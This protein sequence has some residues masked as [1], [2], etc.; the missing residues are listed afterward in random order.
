MKNE[1]NAK[2][3]DVE[4][5]EV[6]ATEVETEAKESFL[7]KAK[8]FGK[9][10][11]KKG[12]IGIGV[13]AGVAAAVVIGSKVSGVDKAIAALP[14]GDSSDEVTGSDDSETVEAA[15]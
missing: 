5:V 10:N 8:A 12:L 7:D 15:E 6:E 2:V 9:R 1:E 11:W 13:V 14:V 4:A 3:V